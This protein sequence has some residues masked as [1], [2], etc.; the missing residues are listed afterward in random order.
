MAGRWRSIV[1][2]F[3]V[4][5]MGVYS[6]GAKWGYIGQENRAPWCKENAG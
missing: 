6:I 4:G 1:W 3:S 2:V 5:R